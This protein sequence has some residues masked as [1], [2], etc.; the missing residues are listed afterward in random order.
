MIRRRERRP[1][2]PGVVLLLLGLALLTLP[3]PHHLKSQ[4]TTEETGEENLDEFFEEVFGVSP[5]PEEQPV[6]LFVDREDYGIVSALVTPAGTLTAVDSD[7]LLSALEELLNEEGVSAV[8]TARGE[9]ETATVEALAE[10]GITVEYDRAS[11][12]LRMSVPGEYRRT[13]QLSI[14]PDRRSGEI[15]EGIAAV[16]PELFSGGSSFGGSI[17]RRRNNEVDDTTWAGSLEMEPF[18]SA[19]DWLITGELDLFLERGEQEMEFSDIYLRR[20]WQENR[21]RLTIGDLRPGTETFQSSAPLQGVE[22]R[23]EVDRQGLTG[24]PLTEFSLDEATEVE[25]VVNETVIYQQRLGPGSYEVVDLPLGAGISEIEIRF[26]DTPLEP[27]QLS[28]P[29]N[30]SLLPRGDQEFSHAL[31]T[32]PL[33]WNGE[34]GSGEF[35]LSSLRLSSLHRY[36]FT[37][38]LSGSA[39]VQLS[40]EAGQLSLGGDTATVA[41]NFGLRSAVSLA[42]GPGFGFGAQARYELFLQAVP[43]RP[44]LRLSAGWVGE[45]LADPER[46]GGTGEPPLQFGIAYGQRIAGAVLGNLRANYRVDPD[47]GDGDYQIS[48]NLTS[49]RIED[50][51]FGLRLQYASDVDNPSA[52]GGFSGVFSIRVTPREAA[53][54]T[55][56]HALDEP[57]TTLA[58]EQAG[59]VGREMDYS[60]GATAAQSFDR[61]TPFERFDLNGR[62]RGRRGS[63]AGSGPWRLEP[64]GGVSGTTATLA[65]QTGVLFAGDTFAW[66]EVLPE[67][68]FA[69]VSIPEEGALSEVSLGAGNPPLVVEPGFLG[70]RAVRGREAYQPIF[71][72]LDPGALPLGYELTNP[73]VAALTGS[74]TGTI[75]IPELAGVVF[76]R[77]IITDPGTGEPVTLVTGRVYPE[78]GSQQSQLV[79]SNREGRF[80]AAGLEAG[81]YVFEASDGRSGRFVVPEQTVGLYDIGTLEVE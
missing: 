17:L 67:Q 37:S 40:T 65:G 32:T 31:G 27:L 52:W 49:P 36:G 62:V 71:L 60:L 1:S 44:S 26:P 41:G 59:G 53:R 77:G 57:R 7:S 66:T 47:S 35:G 42:Q 76:V 3:V 68:S 20:I 24:D 45:R 81:S 79:F 29:F 78:G 55:A 56:T 43:F 12:D 18:F 61:T 25:V 6:R 30:S 10:V 46:P 5:E 2:P 16:E 33:L 48:A 28:R 4:E 23:R 72:S 14:R 34:A 50:V 75:V 51:R 64:E 38:T 70:A 73:R 69:I 80:E 11:F 15:P 54:F 22:V 58:L 8:E 19:Y 9:G 21:L 74:A 13:R 63:A 39:G